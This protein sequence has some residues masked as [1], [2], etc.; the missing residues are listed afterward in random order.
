MGQE[1]SV[2]AVALAGALAAI[3]MWLLGFFLPDLMM[4]TPPGIEAAVS[5]VITAVICYVIPEMKVGGGGS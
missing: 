5:T 2:T 4:T 3:L 1:T